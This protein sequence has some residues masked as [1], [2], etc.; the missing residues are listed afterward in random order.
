MN[1][2]S[3]TKIYGLLG[4]SL[5]HSLSPAMHNAAF[6]EL[7][8]DGQYRLFEKRPE[9][10]EPFLKNLDKENIWG[11]NVTVPYKEKV[12]EFVSFD[13]EY[14]KKV[15]AVN[16]I[17]RRDNG[18]YAFNT[19]VQGFGIHLKRVFGEPAGKKVALLGAG[20]AARAV[21]C[22]LAGASV[23]KIAIFDIDKAKSEGIVRMI[24]SFSPG[25]DIEIVN[26]IEE[27]KINDKD[28]L[29]NATPIGLKE[30]DPCLVGE[31]ML[32]KDLFVYDLIYNPAE[33]KLLALAKKTGAKYSN[34]LGMLISQ[35]AQSFKYF[36]QTRTSLDV[37][38]KIMEKAL[39]K[40]A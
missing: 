29:I 8:I 19:D 9:E 32:H 5:G 15:G 3:T 39:K 27:L 10:I 11:F 7:G 31:E 22:L 21:C 26:S 17:V 34:G 14:I 1:S 33:T 6:R 4:A 18:L 35:G 36:T 2:A 28:L 13:D 38:V 12:L 20:G 24:K 25:C 37:I 23:A 16:T 40:G 30:S